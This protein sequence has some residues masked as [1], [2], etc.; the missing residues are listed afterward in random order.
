MTIAAVIT[1]AGIGRRM[2]MDKPKQYLSV[3]GQP[4]IVH[5][6]NRFVGVQGLRDVVVGVPPEDVASFATRIL[7]AFGFPAHW[8]VI[9]GGD[10]RQQ[11]VHNGL[12]AL[13]SDVEVVVIH[14]GVRPFV[15]RA[16]IERSIEAARSDGACMVGMPLKETIKRVGGESMI[17]ETLDR[18]PLWGAQTPQTFR[19]ALIRE[20]YARATS[21]HFVGTDDAMLVERLGHNVRA[22]AGDYRNIKITTPEDLDI[23]EA[24]AARW[25]NE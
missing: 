20:A 16:T 21:E 8:K 5:T 7:G 1:A 24:I 15:T 12:K 10:V 3:A 14:D 4:I 22:L 6:L 17:H 2:G 13:P 19:F 25:G 23:A 11:S 9:A 18:T